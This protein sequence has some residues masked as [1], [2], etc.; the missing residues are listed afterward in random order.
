[1]CEGCGHF[2]EVLSYKS[3]ALISS[4]DLDLLGKSC[5]FA[6]KCLAC[7]KILESIKHLPLFTGDM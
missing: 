7:F 1:M 6:G 3:W 5:F 4:L 2:Y